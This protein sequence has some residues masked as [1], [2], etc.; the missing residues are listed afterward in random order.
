MSDRAVFIAIHP[1]A[2]PKP[3]EG[4]ACNG[5]GVCCLIE[6]CPVGMVVSRKRR[7]ACVALAWSDAESR[8]VCGMVMQPEAHLPGWLVA[9]PA[10]RGLASRWARRVI[11]AG[12]GCDSNATPE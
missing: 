11:A 10:L 6:P 9:Q 7:G 3:A 5:C 1:A 4:A 2:P 12:A 8:Y